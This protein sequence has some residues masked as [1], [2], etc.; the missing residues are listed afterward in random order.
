MESNATFILLFQLFIVFLFSHS[1]TSQTEEIDKLPNIGL[2]PVSTTPR[3][4]MQLLREG[5]PQVQ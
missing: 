5:N 4:Q 2:Q 1:Q 3:Y